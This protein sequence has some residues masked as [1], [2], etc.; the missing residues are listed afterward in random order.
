MLNRC[1]ICK[2]YNTRHYCYPKSPNL[3]S[4]R[5]DKSTPFSAC[6]IDYVGP[7]YM[8]DVYN[9]HQ[10]DEHQ[11]FKSFVLPVKRSM[12][13]T[14]GNSMVCFNEHRVLLYETELVLH[15]RQA[16]VFIVIVFEEKQP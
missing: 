14:L 7:L 4:F 3:P 16:I 11:L 8:K 15:S 9:D 2:R 12:K 13:K 6:R 5:I 10:E 1:V